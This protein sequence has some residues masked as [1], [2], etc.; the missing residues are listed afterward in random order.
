MKNVK[1]TIEYDGTNYHGWQVQ[2]NAKT[3]QG[4]VERAIR[5]LTGEEITITG[6]SRTDQGVHAYGQV[7]NFLT[8]SNIP[9]DRFSYALNR[10]LPDDIVIKKSEE[11]SLDFHARHCSKGKKY[12]YLIYNSSFPSAIFRNRAYHVSHQLDFEEMQKS[13]GYFLGTHDFSAFRSTGSSV[14]TSV[15]TIFDVK[16]TKSEDNIWFEVSGDGFLY[17]MV[18]IIVGTIVDVGMGRI[19]SKEIPSIIE[20]LE[21]KRAGRTAPPQGLYLVEVYY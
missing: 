9:Q 12:R 21:R 15:R 10:M 1:L 11:V 17:N 14:K 2:S 4:T 13:I 8:Q 18:R 5:G 16:L 20:S 7:A 19:K 3:V 6:S